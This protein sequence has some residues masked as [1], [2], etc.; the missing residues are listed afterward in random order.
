MTVAKTA[1]TSVTDRRHRLD[2]QRHENP[3]RVNYRT[4][5]ATVVV[6][7]TIG[8]IN[9]KTDMTGLGGGDVRG[10]SG[11]RTDAADSLR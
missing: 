10:I 7:G 5:Q 6:R 11:I 2:C 8:G 9:L 4:I 3:A 1:C